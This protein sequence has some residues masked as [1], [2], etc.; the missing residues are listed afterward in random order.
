ME[1]P[2]IRGRLTRSVS[3]EPKHVSSARHPVPERRPDPTGRGRMPP[4]LPP[5]GGHLSGAESRSSGGV[6]RFRNILLVAGLDDGPVPRRVLER[7]LSLARANRAKLTFIGVVHVPEVFREVLSPGRLAR[8]RREQRR[9]LTRLAAVAEERGVETETELVVGKPFLEIVRKVQRS[10]HDL[11]MTQGGREIGAGVIDSTTMQLMRKCPC[12][13]WV[14][15]PHASNPHAGVLAA[16]DPDGTD[17]EKE[18]LNRRIM[19]VAISMAR[20]ESSEVHVVHVWES[21]GIPPGSYGEVWKSWEVTA[22]SEIKRRL[23]E[24]LAEYEL[25]PDPRVHLLA[26]RPAIAISELVSEEQIDLLVM[27][28]VCR[29]GVRGFFVGNT[30]EGVLERVDCSL[31]TVKPDGFASPIQLA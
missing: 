22:R 3:A 16:I 19:E 13:I 8:I 21:S 31:L 23:S 4:P 30:A 11:V 26:G 18:S 6:E 29:T 17:S 2:Q 1:S 27:G 5:T 20:L 24:F 12:T 14:V 9:S 7:A 15:R 25:G 28:T 10:E